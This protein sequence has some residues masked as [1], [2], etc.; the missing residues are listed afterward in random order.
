MT[1][2]ADPA[3][4]H[5]LH[6]VQPVLPVRDVQAAAAWFRDMLGFEIDF[7]VGEPAQHGRVMAGDAS[8]GQPV[9]IHLRR[10]V[11]PVTGGELRLHVGHDLDGLAARLRAAGATLLE[12]PQTQ[13]WGLR[14]CVVATP[15]GHALRLCGEAESAGADAQPRVVIASFRPKPGQQDALRAVVREH[16]PILRRLGLA[17]IR[18][19]Y[20]VRAADG[21]VVE[22]FEW[23]SPAAIEAAHSHPEV[24]ALWERFAAACDYISLNELAEAQHPFAE[25]QPL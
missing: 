21:S 20:A 18:P 1:T 14:E 7:I 5:Q 25:F 3:R 9:Y 4:H 10:S 8:W 2:A 11:Q 16:V 17:T 13:P 12:E 23:M 22:V 6:G 15:D 19:A 24:L